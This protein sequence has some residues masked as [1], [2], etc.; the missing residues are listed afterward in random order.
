MLLS[1]KT[2]EL[3][4]PPA[5]SI[6]HLVKVIR[7]PHDVTFVNVPGVLVS[8]TGTLSDG[9]RI[10]RKFLACI[11]AVDDRKVSCIFV[12]SPICPVGR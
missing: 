8:N 1:V 7:M 2:Y 3:E 6:F 5:V 4:A 11:K 12:T 9:I 10:Y